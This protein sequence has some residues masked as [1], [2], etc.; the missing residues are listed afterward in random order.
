MND[1][2]VTDTRRHAEDPLTD[3][4]TVLATD[5]RW[6]TVKGV[7]E[8]LHDDDPTVIPLMLRLIRSGHITARQEVRRYIDFTVNQVAQGMTYM[9]VNHDWRD[10]CRYR[11]SP[12]SKHSLLSTWHFNQLRAEVDPTGAMNFNKPVTSAMTHMHKLV[13]SD[14]EDFSDAHWRG[15]AATAIV[16]QDSWDAS[17]FT[18]FVT[19]AGDHDDTA[20]IVLLAI[21]RSTIDPNYIEELLKAQSEVHSAFHPGIL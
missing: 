4:L 1:L 6:E 8:V 17:R 15:L 16:V 13:S 14:P 12:H 3:L 5:A 10:G 19:Y 11:F 20:R 7:L 2:E 21:E 18:P 9:K